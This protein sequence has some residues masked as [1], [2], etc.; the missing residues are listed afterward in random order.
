[1]NWIKGFK[2]RDVKNIINSKKKIRDNKKYYLL[3]IPL[4]LSK[5]PVVVRTVTPIA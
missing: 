5:I 1:M 4:I 3:K 2:K